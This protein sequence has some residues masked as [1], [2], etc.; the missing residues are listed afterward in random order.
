MALSTAV[1]EPCLPALGHRLV[2]TFA[3]P[4]LPGGCCQAESS[5]QEWT[6]NATSDARTRDAASEISDAR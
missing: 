4:A 5:V 1:L 3:E 2:L 6:A